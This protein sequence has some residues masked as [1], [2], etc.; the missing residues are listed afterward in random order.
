ML[1]FELQE[2]YYLHIY[3]GKLDQVEDFS[4]NL[5]ELREIYFLEETRMF[6]FK[7]K[8]KRYKYALEFNHQNNYNDENIKSHK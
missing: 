4:I 1:W 3:G 8:D 5:S 2:D 6:I 7:G